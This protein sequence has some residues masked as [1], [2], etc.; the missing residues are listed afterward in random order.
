MNTNQLT[1]TEQKMLDELKTKSFTKNSLITQLIYY[2][3]FK[4]ISTLFAMFIF[5]LAIF[6]VSFVIYLNGFGFNIL[7]CGIYLISHFLFFKFYLKKRYYK[8]LYLQHK[9][10]E[11]ADLIISLRLRNGLY[12]IKT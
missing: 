3:F 11:E 4:L 6:S 1:K 10:M 8:I 5:T 2:R 12:E 9:L 7:V